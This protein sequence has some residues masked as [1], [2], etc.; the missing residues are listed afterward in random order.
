MVIPI[1]FSRPG[2]HQRIQIRKRIDDGGSFTGIDGRTASGTAPIM[3]GGMFIIMAIETQ[4]F[5]IASIRWIVFEV[6][7]LV[8]H[9]Q[10]AQPFAFELTATARADMREQLERSIAIIPF[11]QIDVF[12]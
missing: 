8:M 11:A 9:R 7:V 10:F 5:P 12:F 2:F 6:L 1:L 4:E 3:G